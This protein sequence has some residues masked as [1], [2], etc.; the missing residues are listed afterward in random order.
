MQLATENIL[1]LG[2][3]DGHVLE[4]I[5]AARP[6][7]TIVRADT[8]FDGLAELHA[9]PFSAVVAAVEPMERRPEPAVRAIRQLVGV[10]ARLLLYGNTTLEPLSR[11]MLSVGVDDYFVTPAD[12]AEL[13]Q[14][15]STPAHE[16]PT[17]PQ[18]VATPEAIAAT[19]GTISA[20]E[21]LQSALDVMLDHPQASTAQLAKRLSMR[22]PRGT[23]IRYATAASATLSPLAVPIRNATQVAGHLDVDG[24]ALDD[25][26]RIAL[27]ARLAPVFGKVALLEQRH[28]LMQKLAITDELTGL[29]N[30]RYFHHFLSRMMEKARAKRFAVTL[31]LFDIDNFKRYNDQF[32]HGVGDEILR[33][34]AS[35]M[36]RCCRDHDLVARIGGD[37]FAVVFW[38]KDAPRVPYD[39]HAAPHS[40]VP[41]TPMI[42]AQRFRKLLG[43]SE[44]SA[45]G[46]AGKGVLT[47]S[48][49]M[50]VYPFDG[51]TPAELIKSADAAQ[52][53]GAKKSGKNSIAL[54][55]DDGTF[56]AGE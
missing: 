53:F 40:R 7:A 12:P 35:L 37:E 29:Y 8:L 9:A 31:L 13:R 38:E 28:A 43:S 47:I 22:M 3:R 15:F 44:F 55:G 14:V 45:L 10:K 24:D 52:M 4:A 25:A 27:L 54:V 50:A 1:L 48:G 32:G 21:L 30:A 23:R 49:G 41:S 56:F 5:R 16:E 17:E 20:D 51:H 39:P 18:T 2:D 36:R 6:D 34:T 11:K 26:A 33:Q 42:I 46:P 19:H